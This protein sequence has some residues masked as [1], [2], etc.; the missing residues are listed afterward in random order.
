MACSDDTES[1]MTPD[2][3]TSI[4]DTGAHPDATTNAGPDA[5]MNMDADLTPDAAPPDWDFGTKIADIPADLIAVTPDEKEVIYVKRV[6]NRDRIFAYETD[7]G[8]TREIDSE[9]YLQYL[10]N[11]QDETRGIV[12]TRPIMWYFSDLLRNV[13]R[14]WQS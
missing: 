11:E 9:Q 7:T 6:L 2:A 12:T 13:S 3:S 4:P 8:M 10:H 14:K 5:G 1:A